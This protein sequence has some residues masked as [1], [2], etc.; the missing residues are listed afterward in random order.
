MK[1]NGNNLDVDQRA[2]HRATSRQ[3]RCGAVRKAVAS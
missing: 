2:W 1:L 3:G